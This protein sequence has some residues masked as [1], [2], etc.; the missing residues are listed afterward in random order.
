MKNRC[1]PLAG[2]AEVANPNSITFAQ[3]GM[4][5]AAEVGW[6]LSDMTEPS[7]CQE[8]AVE[9]E[10]AGTGATANKRD[11][12][13][14]CIKRNT[15][16]RKLATKGD[17]EPIPDQAWPVVSEKAP[18]DGTRVMQYQW[19]DR[20]SVGMTE[21]L[22][23]RNY[24]EIPEPRIPGVFLELAEEARNIILVDDQSYD[25]EDVQPQR[26]GLARPVF[27]TKMIDSPPVLKNRALRVTS[28]STEMIP[29][30][31]LSGRGEP[32][33]R[34]GPVGPQNNTEQ[35]VLLGFNTDKRGNAPTGLVGPQNNTKQ[36]VLLGVNTDKRGNAP[37]GP[38]GHDVM[39]AGRGEMVD[40]PD[41]MGPHSS[42]EQSVFLGLDVDQVEH[43]S[44]NIVH[45]G[46]KMFRN[47]PV[48]E[49]PAGPD[50]TRRPVGTDGMHAVHDADRP[51]AGGPL[52]R[53]FNL[54]PL[55]PS[56]MPSLDELNQP[57]AMGPLG[58]EGIHAVNN[59]DRPAAGGPVGRL[60]SLD[61]MGP[62]GMSS[63]GDGNQP[64]AVGPVGK[65]FITGR[66][67]D[68]VSEPDCRRTIQT[69]S[70]SES[71]TGVPDPVIQTGSDVQTDRV[72]I[73]TANGPADKWNSDRGHRPEVIVMIQLKRNRVCVI[74]RSLI[75]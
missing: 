36:P 44:A 54:D 45:P 5:T 55:G 74:D 27:V 2:G 15:M 63:S 40:W 53:L 12:S 59:S 52:G 7:R 48:T 21:M 58:T 33:N 9:A 72:N 60:F 34:S 37:T 69:R 62:S 28:T 46:V 49:G 39:L 43:V 24:L 31:N 26:T 23:P 3:K 13:M 42:T 8:T 56:R 47:H 70:E 1:R 50:R 67:G 22:M 10:G 29:N 68:Q 19:N 64:P 25:T 32:V 17:M 14:D 41:L 71:A 20:E 51:T 73:G 16:G 38:V 30:I 61:P 6:N 35:P 65:P 57:L 66:L 11:R 4:T 75:R 18:A